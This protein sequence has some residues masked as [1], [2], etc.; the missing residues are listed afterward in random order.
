MVASTSRGLGRVAVLTVGLSASALLAHKFH[1]ATAEV[2]VT[3][4]GGIEVTCK[5]HTEDLEKALR[6]R[7]GR[8]LE[9]DRDPEAKAIAC[10]FAQQHFALEPAVGPFE[11]LG[12]EIGNHFTNIYLEAKRPASAASQALPQRVRFSPLLDLLPSQQNR[13]VLQREGRPLLTRAVAKS[14]WA[15]LGSSASRP[16]PAGRGRTT[17]ADT[18]D[19][20][21]K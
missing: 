13:V 7:A 1:F 20:A 6:L 15:N 16:V 18:A 11:C 8:E 9:I 4:Q 2:N 17:S 5:F 3:G 19:K 10:S 14:G 12:W 21:K